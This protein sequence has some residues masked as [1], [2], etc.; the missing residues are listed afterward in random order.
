[1]LDLE[2]PGEFLLLDADRAGPHR[3]RVQQLDGNPDDL[4]DGSP[5]RLEGR[6]RGEP[7]PQLLEP[8]LQVGVVLLRGIDARF[9]D[10]VPVEGEPGTVVGLHLVRDSDVG[11]Q[12]RVAGPGVT[13]GERGGDQPARGDLSDTAGAPACE[14]GVL[15]Q[16]VEGVGDRLV[17][18]LADQGSE[19][20]VGQCPEC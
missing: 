15:L 1:M 16:P 6:P 3:P 4:A 7:Q 20:R 10:R 9:V 8:G 11:V 17:M 5:F 18:G 13:V 12:V 19:L 14:D 2:T